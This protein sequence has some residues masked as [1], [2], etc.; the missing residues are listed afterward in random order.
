[1][2]L[3]LALVNLPA[4][5]LEKWTIEELL[6]VRQFSDVSISPDGRHVLYSLSWTQAKANRRVTDIYLVDTN[7]SGERRLTRDGTPKSEPRWL[8]GGRVAYRSSGKLWTVP[9]GGGTP[10]EV[11]PAGLPIESYEF[12]PGGD[13]LLYVTKEPK[14]AAQLAHESEWG[15]VISFEEQ[16]P[17]RASLWVR[18]APDGAPRRVAGPDSRPREPHF[19]PDARMFAYLDA[20]RLWV[21]RPGGSAEP[22]GRSVQFFA[23]APDSR[24]IAYIEAVPDP[25]PYGNQFQRPIYL[26]TGAVWLVDAAGGEPRRLTPQDYPGLARLVWSRDSRRLAF[27]ARSPGARDHR[28][29]LEKLHILDLNGAIRTAA[30]GFDFYRGGAAMTW[31]KDNSEIWFLN[32][33]RM[34]Y[35]IFAADAAS[36]R[37][38]HVTQGQNVLSHVSFSADF[39]MVAF[40]RENANTPPDV[41]VTASSLWREKKITTINP[42]STRF[43]HGPGEIIRY[44]SEGREIEALLVKPPDFDPA[45]KYPLLL[46][47]HGGPTW[48]KKN[49]WRPEW[50]QHPIQVYA[51]E[52]YCLVFPNVRGSADYG[53]EF[54]T[55]NYRDL[56]G[57]D[58]RDA[59][60]AV[61]HLIAR[62]FV[63][64]RRL[65]V[66]GW[67]YGGYL[68]PAII[69]KTGRFQAAQFG[70]GIPSL[71]AMYSRLSTV[72]WIVHDN[73]G[74][75]PW[76][77][78]RM[79]IQ[80][81]PL[82]SAWKV[83]TPTLI[84]HGEDDPRCPVA[85]SILFY[86][87]LKSY[88][89]PVVLEIYPKEGHGIL[90]PK[91][92]RRCLRRHVDWFNKWLKADRTTPFERLFPS[93]P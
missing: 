9:V 52:G 42:Q 59:M 82:Y 46:I 6:A 31:S 66:A 68:T 93:A 38:R 16:W 41:H 74:Q 29:E 40:V 55:A 14:S 80:D 73:Y 27:L 57:G 7:G 25:Q 92:R 3:F 34:G 78:A 39:S 17:E 30:P 21:F 53:V 45:K 86:K 69:A 20:G 54:R 5:A 2:T 71:E 12:S 85:G 44:P 63:D 18:D 22:V 47:L 8:S 77:D 58:F 19:S 33:E 79:H 24:S 28:T 87:A 48:Y 36:G 15:A 84:E 13:R 67:S 11:T 60:A 43:A 37:L 4:R 61:D 65:G 89:V 90:D 64:P 91:L 51:A 26:G 49:D 35:N 23:W 32:G 75:R 10:R 76:D 70:A 83:K 62:G 72:E 88:G 56:G 1:M 50:E 81:S